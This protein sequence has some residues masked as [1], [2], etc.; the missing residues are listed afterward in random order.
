MQNPSLSRQ[1]FEDSKSSL[2]RML[3]DFDQ[4]R[5][6]HAS[7]SEAPGGSDVEDMLES[8]MKLVMTSYEK[9]MRR[10]L[11]NLV[12]GNLV[13]AMLIQVGHMDPLM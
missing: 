6:R 1:E 8:G 3:T 4:D 7:G 2:L 10:P 13:R 12:L 9:E 11:R 5:Q